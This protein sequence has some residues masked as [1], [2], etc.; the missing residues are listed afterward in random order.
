MMVYKQPSIPNEDV[1]KSM[2]FV[3]SQ[4]DGYPYKNVLGNKIDIFYTSKQG[5]QKNN[6]S[7]DQ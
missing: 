2:T 7:I 5:D 3:M 6:Y 4:Q 1:P